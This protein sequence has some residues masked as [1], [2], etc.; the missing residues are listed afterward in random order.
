MINQETLKT[1]DELYNESYASVLKYVVCNCKNLDDAL[2][3]VQSVYLELLKALQ[4]GKTFLNSKAYIMGITKNKVNLYYRFKYKY[5]IVSLFLQE[6]E[7]P[8][9]IDNLADG[10]VD[11]E[12]E[13]GQKDDLEFIWNFLRKKKRV[14]FKVFYLYYY[15][16]M[17]IKNIS[18]E[19]GI[20]E[21]NVKHYLYRTLNELKEKM[22][23][24]SDKDV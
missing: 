9:L 22:I 2:D 10:E 13:L 8:A 3:I 5:K 12:K 24:R 23:K 19:L 4:K 17:T 14:I 1:F 18:E 11:L 20:S 6:D 15:E 7:S 16:D 21:A